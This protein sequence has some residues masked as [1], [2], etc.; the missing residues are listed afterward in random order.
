M[1]IRTNKIKKRMERED[2]KGGNNAQRI[3]AKQAGTSV[4]RPENASN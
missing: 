2:I 1:I 3:T 4:V